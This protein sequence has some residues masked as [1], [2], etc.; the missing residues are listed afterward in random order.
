LF[1]IRKHFGPPILPKGFFLEQENPPSARSLNN[2]LLKCNQVKYP[3]E[4]LSLALKKSLFHLSIIEELSGDMFG[5]V[6]ATSDQG[7]NAN[8][9]NLVASPG[10]KQEIFFSVLIYKALG[11]LRKD[12]PGCSIS[13]SAPKSSFRALKDQGFL[14]DPTGIRAMGIKLR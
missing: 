11:I 2:L 9:W 1:P 3:S 4:R 6:R 5:F 13:V 10:D 7:L 12:M 14:I 8:L